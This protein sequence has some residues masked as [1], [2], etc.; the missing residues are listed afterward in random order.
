MQ[1]VQN[2]MSIKFES[3]SV[4]K[5]FARQTV[6]AF[7]AQLDPTLEEL[8]DIKTAVSEAVTN[9]IVHGYADRLGYITVSAKLLEGGK[10]EI[11]VKDSG[12]GIAD[13][14]KAREPMFTTGD[15]TRSGMGFTIRERFMDK[16][17]VRSTEGK[18]TIVT[19]L[20][21]LTLRDGVR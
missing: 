5:A 20:R 4:N 14:E 11:K 9:A 15:D 1:N 17:R 10:I 3:R 12:R 2:S 21:T 6:A 8:N 16:L 7:V 13:I 19:M 18:G